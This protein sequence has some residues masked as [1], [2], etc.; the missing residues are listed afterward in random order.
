MNNIS[1]IL[2]SAA[3]VFFALSMFGVLAS[4][5]NP[6]GPNPVSP[7]DYLPLALGNRWVYESMATFGASPSV[8]R[9]DSSAIVG[10]TVK[11]G[12]S[13]YLF[14]PSL[15]GWGNTS[16]AVR[17][18]TDGIFFI[19]YG[20]TEIAQWSFSAATQTGLVGLVILGTNDTVVTPGGTYYHCLRIGP[21]PS[22]RVAEPEMTFCPGVGL[23]EYRFF[24]VDIITQTELVRYTLTR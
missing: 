13:Y 16:E 12:K 11:N 4:C 24:G 21:A 6:A 19:L 15:P 20:D 10:V 14:D 23:V 1:R 3:Q 2:L 5:N 7:T 18:D 8:Q 17:I 9:V 22:S